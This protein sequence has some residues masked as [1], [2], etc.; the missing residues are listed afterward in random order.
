MNLIPLLTLLGIIA[1]ASFAVWLAGVVERNTFSLGLSILTLILVLI[2]PFG[3][4]LGA[5]S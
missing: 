1:Y 4:M 5:H 3:L 2:V